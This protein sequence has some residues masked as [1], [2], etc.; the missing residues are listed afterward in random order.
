MKLF[1]L[2]LIALAIGTFLLAYSCKHDEK[3]TGQNENKT[4][5]PEKADGTALGG[6]W[7]AIDF[8][9]RTNQY[10]SVLAA[11]NNSHKPYSYA[12]TFDP[13]KLDS[14]TCYNGFE[15]WVL[16]IKISAD[17]LVEVQNAVQGKPVYLAFSRDDQSLTLF[18]GTSGQTYLDRFIKSKANTADGL[19]AFKTALNHNLLSGVFNQAGKSSAPAIQFTPGGFI[20]N[21]PEFDRYEVCIG[22]DCFVAGQKIDVMA[23]KNSKKEGSQKF[24]GYRYSGQNDTLYIYNL[25]NKKPDEKFA[26]E[27]GAKAYTL[28]RKKSER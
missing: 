16:P 15:R 1:T 6:H 21:F 5:K 10:G 28:I 3:N 20:N 18:D 25:I 12:F 7:V 19:D 22:G 14:V 11:M 24:F 2:P 8:C 23:W 4:Q 13:A 27:V 26:Y 17:T 9:A